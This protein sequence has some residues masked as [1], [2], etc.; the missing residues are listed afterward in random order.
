MTDAAFCKA[1]LWM[2]A[3]L[4]HMKLDLNHELQVVFLH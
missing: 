3:D 2:E 1:K 4:Q